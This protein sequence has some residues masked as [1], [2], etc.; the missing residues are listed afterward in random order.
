MRYIE[1]VSPVL[2]LKLIVI[3]GNYVSPNRCG[4]KTRW[5]QSTVGI[6]F[7][8]GGR[9]TF[10]NFPLE[11]IDLLNR[12]GVDSV[13]YDASV[14]ECQP[15]VFQKCGL[16]FKSLGELKLSTKVPLTNTTTIAP[17]SRS[18]QTYSWCEIFEN[19]IYKMWRFRVGVMIQ[20]D[21]SSIHTAFQA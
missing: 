16:F 15:I 14:V 19:A 1:V 18:I 17:A 13:I 11:S 2:R 9:N 3:W 10:T 21:L 5:M 6:K 12:L 7:W 8:D 20:R 4:L